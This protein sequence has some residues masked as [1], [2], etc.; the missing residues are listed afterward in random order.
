MRSWWKNLRM[1]KTEKEMGR[2]HGNSQG[3]ESDERRLG[4]LSEAEMVWLE[5]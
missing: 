4:R 1:E 5:M 3:R 2:M